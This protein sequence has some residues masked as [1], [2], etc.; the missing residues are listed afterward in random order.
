MEPNRAAPRPNAM[1]VLAVVAIWL[2]VLIAVSGCASDEEKPAAQSTPTQTS[3]PAPD[4]PS[5]D[6]TINTRLDEPRKF[7][8][9][10]GR[11][12]MA[13]NSGSGGPL[14]TTPVTQGT[15]RLR[16][17]QGSFEGNVDS[18]G[19]FEM[20]VRTGRYYAE[21]GIL[22]EGGGGF[23]CKTFDGS[24]VTVTGREPAITIYCPRE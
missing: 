5:D 19:R 10:R 18:N 23:Q 12:M 6:P 11:L 14:G 16:S 13:A 20:K 3:T 21:G 4:V 24:P 22:E 7:V 1:K 9:V 17:S 8:T 2:V 15:V